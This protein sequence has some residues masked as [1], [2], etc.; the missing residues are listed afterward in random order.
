MNKKLYKIKLRDSDYNYDTKYYLATSL[1]EIDKSLSNSLDILEIEILP[2]GDL[3]E[4][5]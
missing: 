5:F 4:M 1:S 2:F 3:T